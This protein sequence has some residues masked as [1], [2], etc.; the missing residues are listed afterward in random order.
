[1]TS[2]EQTLVDREH[3]PGP[4]YLDGV[5]IVEA[6]RPHMR[7]CFLHAE[8]ATSKPNGHLIKSAPDLLDAVEQALDDMG[9]DGKCIAQ[10]TKDMMLSAYK[11]A[12]G[13]TT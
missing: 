5:Q 13:R 11:R 3:T 4:W 7:V 8:Y 10:S 12:I 9:D 6:N 1:M 2:W